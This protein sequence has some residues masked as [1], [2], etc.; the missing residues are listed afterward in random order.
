MGRRDGLIPKGSRDEVEEIGREKTSAKP[1]Q[2]W[3]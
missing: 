2:P 3:I 1:R